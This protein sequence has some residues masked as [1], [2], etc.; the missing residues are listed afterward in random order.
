MIKEM[1]KIYPR[2]MSLYDSQRKKRL[3]TALL[4]KS[5]S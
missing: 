4:A 5:E 1:E 2:R 3:K